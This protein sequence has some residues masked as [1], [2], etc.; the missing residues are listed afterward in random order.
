MGFFGRIL[1]KAEARLRW[2]MILALSERFKI[3]KKDKHF[4]CP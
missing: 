2:V 3:S 4:Q 1:G